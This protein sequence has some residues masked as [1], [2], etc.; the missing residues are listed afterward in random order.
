MRK[1]FLREGEDG[2]EF[3]SACSPQVVQSASERAGTWLMT[4]RFDDVSDVLRQGG[5]RDCGVMTAAAVGEYTLLP[6]LT[7]YSAV[8]HIHV[9]TTQRLYS[10]ALDGRDERI[11]VAA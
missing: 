10:S 8:Q 7:A 5:Y 2:G 11:P 4:L 6:L 9:L 3:L 1:I